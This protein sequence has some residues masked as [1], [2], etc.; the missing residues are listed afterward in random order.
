M[1]DSVL[2][3]PAG[4]SV[5]PLTTVEQAFEASAVLSEV[6][7]GDSGGMPPNLLRALAHAGNYA[8]GLYDGDRMIGASVAFFAEPGARSMHSHITGI[9]D[10]YRAHGLGRMLKQHQRAWALAR[11]VGHVTW[12]FDPLVARNAHFNLAVLGARV[13]EYLVDHYG[14]MDD[15]VNRGDET[16]RL[17][18]SWALAAP[19]SAPREADVVTSVEVPADIEEL[20]RENP[21][22][23]LDWRYRVRDAMTGLLQDGFV[24]AGFDDRGYLFGRA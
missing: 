22:A 3:S 5:R 21:E 23:A 12:T 1:S 18:T 2:P 9:V 16:D 14:A 4:I 13:T 8:V 11:D 20:R 10:G 17:M 24:V 7:G 6:W 19:A 15:G